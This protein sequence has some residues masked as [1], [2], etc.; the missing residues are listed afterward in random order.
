M[1]NWNNWY[2]MRN[3][4][5]WICIWEIEITEHIIW[6]IERNEHTVHEKLWEIEEHSLLFFKQIYLKRYLTKKGQK[7]NKILD[8][9][10]DIQP[11]LLSYLVINKSWAKSHLLRPAL[12]DQ[13]KW[14]LFA[15]SSLR[16]VEKYVDLILS[17]PP[18]NSTWTNYIWFDAV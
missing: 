11:Q 8:L 14:W 13:R 18:G 15:L 16:F 5:N 3:W 2:Y 9:F 4:N 7:T 12:V 17:Q 1:R 6:E 10:Y